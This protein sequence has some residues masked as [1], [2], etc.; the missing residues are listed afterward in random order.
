MIARLNENGQPWRLHYC[1]RA[2]DRAAFVA[3]LEGLASAGDGELIPNYD[4]D[5]AGML[6]LEA[7]L[8]A[9]PADAHIY[10]CGPTAMIAAVRAGAQSAGI[11]SPRSEEH[12]SEL[13]SLMRNSYAVFC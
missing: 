5:P 8:A 9:I 4:E 3:E 13:Q 11:A 6:D 1:V 7:T 12:T 10:C 2:R